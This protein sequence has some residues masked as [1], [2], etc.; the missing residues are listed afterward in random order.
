M[1]SKEERTDIFL[2][3]LA[4]AKACSSASEALSLLSST[5]NAVEDE[6]T[7]IPN[8]PHLW[9]SDGRLYP[10]RDDSRRTVPDRDDIVRYRSRKHNTWIAENGAIKITKGDKICLDK[11]GADGLTL[12]SL[13]GST[14]SSA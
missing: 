10:P 4:N 9:E 6:F 5:L 11:P 14:V 2:R 7:S 8:N 13:M 3:R 1:L 12:T